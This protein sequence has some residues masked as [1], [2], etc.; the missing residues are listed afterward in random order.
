MLLAQREKPL[1]A[2]E[3]DA[4]QVVIEVFGWLKRHLF[5]QCLFTAVRVHL[6]TALDRLS[7]QLILAD[8]L[9]LE[10]V[11]HALGRLKLF[12]DRVLRRFN[13][14]CLAEYVTATSCS[15]L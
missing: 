11:H 12:L 6:I 4:S 14:D 8:Y 9:T 7:S 15:I 2:L 1:F 3:L 13:I 10:S 5:E